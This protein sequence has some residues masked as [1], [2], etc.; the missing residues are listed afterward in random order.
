MVMDASANLDSTY[1][2]TRRDLVE[3]ALDWKLWCVL[4]WNVL[5]SIAPQG[6]TI[7]FPIVV[8]VFNSTSGDRKR[9]FTMYFSHNTDWTRVWDIPARLQSSFS[10]SIHPE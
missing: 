10:P 1:K 9:S 4:P 7:F 6:F 2:M 5:A 8:K 3:G